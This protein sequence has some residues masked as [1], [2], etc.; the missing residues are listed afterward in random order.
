MSPE[1]ARGKT[2]D[3][4]TDIWSF[5]CVLFEML[6]GRPAFGGETLSDT[7]AGILEREPDWSALP[8]G[9]PPRLRELT[10]RCLRKDVRRRLRDIGDARIELDEMASHPEDGETAAA[11]RAAGPQQRR[12]ARAIGLAAGVALVAVVVAATAWVARRIGAAQP[13]F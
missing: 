1:Q 6:G 12:R 11:E 13:A 3:T 9:V 2:L 4:R 10:R 8:L 5:G 7:I